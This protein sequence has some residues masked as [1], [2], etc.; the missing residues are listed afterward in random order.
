MPVGQAPRGREY[1]P[2]LAVPSSPRSPSSTTGT[3][4]VIPNH[5]PDCPMAEVHELDLAAVPSGCGLAAG[6]P[7]PNVLR[8]ARG[9]S[10][11]PALLLCQGGVRFQRVEDDACELSFEAADRLAAALPL[12]LFALEVG[13]RRRVHPC[14]RDGDPV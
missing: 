10:H 14:L 8:R 1:A 2:H 4:A 3:S 7:Y 9:S 12:G 6:A 11:G 13:A 5:I